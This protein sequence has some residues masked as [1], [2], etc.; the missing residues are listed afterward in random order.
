MKKQRWHLELAVLLVLLSF[1]LYA[2]HYAI[3]EDAHHIFIYTL[4]DIAFI[5]IEILVVSL[6]VHSAL[7]EREKR[8]RL[9]KL[10][11]V[12]GTFFSEVG[13]QLLSYLADYDPHADEI[14][15]DL[16]MKARQTGSDFGSLTTTLACY[17]H[18][19]DIHKIDLK[20]L[21]E[22]LMK[23]RDFLLRLLENPNML[24]HET[25][26][27]LLWAVFH[28]AEELSYRKNIDE[29]PMSDKEHLGG[30][31]KRAYSAVTCQWISYL[32]H[33]ESSYP[34]LYSLALRTNPFDREASAIV[35]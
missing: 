15:K 1:V 2:I 6:V 13:I 22:M 25:F 29:L 32:R 7:A 28:L 14:R 5:P 27:D 3:F 35:K 4:G 17:E 20:V 9:Q 23:K 34:Y 26:T 11:M 31:I 21:R 8:S 12:I 33:L 19:V 10:N 18:S 24:E 16:Q 30:D